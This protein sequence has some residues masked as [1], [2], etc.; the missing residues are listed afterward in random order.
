MLPDY[1]TKQEAKMLVKPDNW[2]FFNQPPAMLEDRNKEK[3]LEGYTDNPKKENGK[4]LTR[5]Y[6]DS[7]VRGKSKSWIDVYVLK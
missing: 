5:N 6:Y 2:I 4:N 7:I 1:I 3:E